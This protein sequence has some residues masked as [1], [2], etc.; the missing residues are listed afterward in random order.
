[1][2]DSLDNHQ[3]EIPPFIREDLRSPM[4]VDQS[5]H[6]VNVKGQPIR[7]ELKRLEDPATSKAKEPADRKPGDMSLVG[8]VDSESLPVVGKE[9]KLCYYKYNGRTAYNIVATQSPVTEVV[10][11][12][13]FIYFSVGS[14]HWRLEILSDEN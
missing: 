8:I 3:L 12:I 7:V 13:P 2:R 5:H 14:D 11:A 6:F 9:F 1:M 4:L 10:E